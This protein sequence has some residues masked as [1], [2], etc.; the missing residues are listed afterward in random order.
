[1]IIDI[2]EQPEHIPQLAAW[3]QA[4]WASL[5]PGLS[6]EGRVA[7]MQAYLADAAL[8]RLFVAVQDQLLLGSAALVDADMDSRPDLTPW[9]A[10][11][12]VRDS[13]RRAGLGTAL[14]LHLAAYAK[15]LGHSQLYLFTPHQERFYQGLGWQLLSHEHYRQEPVSLMVKGL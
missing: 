1:M 2:R 6:L 4:E 5:N 10:S 12:Y 13:C 14:V 8:P 9:L 7:K 11:V 3:H 15:A